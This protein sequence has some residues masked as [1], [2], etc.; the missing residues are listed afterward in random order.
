MMPFVGKLSVPIKATEASIPSSF[1][2]GEDSRP[3]PSYSGVHLLRPDSANSRDLHRSSFQEESDESNP[4]QGISAA[5]GLRKPRSFC[6]HM[7]HR[8]ICHRLT[9]N[10]LLLP[11]LW[12]PRFTSVFLSVDVRTEEVLRHSL[13]TS[14]RIPG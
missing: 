9:R 13:R 6:S 7:F 10:C 5:K 14:E 8:L 1:P 11:T 12:E 2:S 4:I 3:L